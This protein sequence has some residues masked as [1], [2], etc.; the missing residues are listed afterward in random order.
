MIL[1]ITIT[2]LI[3]IH[4]VSQSCHRNQ[5]QQWQGQ[6]D[7]RKD[8]EQSDHSN[9]QCC[10]HLKAHIKMKKEASLP[11]LI[12]SP[13]LITFDLVPLYFFGGICHWAETISVVVFDLFCLCVLST[14]GSNFRPI[15]AQGLI[16]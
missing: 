13:N 12:I 9:K 11:P 7:E 14:N 10:K 2:L 4:I 5:L 16:V 8:R 1:A 6:V 15:G 3:L